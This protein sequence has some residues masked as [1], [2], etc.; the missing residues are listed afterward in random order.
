MNSTA[1]SF[2]RGLVVIGLIA[3]AGLLFLATPGEVQANVCT[4]SGGSTSWSNAS[5]WTCDVGTTPR[6]G[7]GTDTVG[8]AHNI[9]LD[10]DASTGSV[11]VTANTLTIGDGVVG[12]TL[13]ITGD[14][15]VGPG[16]VATGT[17]NNYIIASGNVQINDTGVLT[18]PVGITLSGNWIN[19][20]GSATRF[21]A[22]TGTA[23][24]FTGS[25]VEIQ[26]NTRSDFRVLRYSASVPTHRLTVNAPVRANDRIDLVQGTLLLPAANVGTCLALTMTQNSTFE[27]GG[28]ATLP[29]TSWV[30][31]GGSTVNYLG[32]DQSVRSAPVYGNLTIST[33]GTKTTNGAILVK[34]NLSVSAG[35][36]IFTD[37]VEHFG[38]TPGSFNIASGAIVNFTGVGSF[39]FDGIDTDMLFDTS[40]SEI[41]SGSTVIYS[42]AVAQSISTIPESWTIAPGYASLQISN[43]NT[44]TL[45][46]NLHVRENLY[47]D[48]GATLAISG[49]P[50]TLY[51]GGQWVNDGTF[52]PGTNTVQFYGSAMQNIQGMTTTT[53]YNM[54]INNTSTDSGVVMGC[55]PL[56]CA[57]VTNTLNFLNGRVILGQH[58]MTMASTATAVTGTLD[59]TRMVIADDTGRMCRVFP[60][61]F[62]YTFPIGDQTQIAAESNYVQY[63][64][65]HFSLGAGGET[66][67]VNLRNARHPQFPAS[68]SNYV[69]RYWTLSRSGTGPLTNASGNFFYDEADAV[70]NDDNITPLKYNAVDGWTH[71][72][73]PDWS[74]DIMVNRIT[75]T[76]LTSLS[77][78]TAADHYPTSVNVEY[79]RARKTSGGV[80]LAWKTIDESDLSGFSIFRRE[81]GGEYVQLN[82]TAIPSLG[83]GSEYTWT[84]ASAVAGKRYEYLLESYDTQLGLAGAP[85]PLVYW[86]YMLFLSLVH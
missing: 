47:I 68:I 51:V 34:N 46:G 15:T 72:Y 65:A 86:P 62:G 55:F 12:R 19:N 42:A 70:T 43:S 28:T 36:L 82:V 24:N 85:V 22:G 38:V 49:S 56:N 9:I 80:E 13:T 54:T 81:P 73:P 77:D 84:D 5:A 40:T 3:L 50:R 29:C 33:A 20:S 1:S 69:R 25:S 32:S 48:T 37:T 18:A 66:G 78:F 11:T 53:F 75:Y 59:S 2:V 7:D 61:S 52:T 6:T 45:S 35:T 26:G 60:D 41:E 71:D 23:V 17:G 27:V 58:D 8:I 63:S 67:C 4:T 14:L 79:F 64:P 74:I 39:N 31:D 21:T 30:L 76:G 57:T 10:Q 83:S 44:K 16:T